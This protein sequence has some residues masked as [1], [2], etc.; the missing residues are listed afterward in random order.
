MFTNWVATAI[1]ACIAGLGPAD[2]SDSSAKMEQREKE[3]TTVVTAKGTEGRVK[4]AAG[5]LLAVRLPVQGGTGYSY[6]LAKQNE[7]IL[8]SQGEP[9]VE[10]EGQSRPGGPEF[11]VFRF[12]AQT[13]GS[14]RP[15]VS[16][17]AVVG[18]K[19]AGKNVSLEGGS[20]RRRARARRS[21]EGSAPAIG[22]APGRWTG[23]KP[24]AASSPKPTP[25]A[26]GTP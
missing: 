15:A 2:L 25:D 8:Q 19:A 9:K 11:H 23:R 3:P 6:R 16:L 12:R 26:P 5:S 22:G 10:H 17:R 14:R 13:K 20:E 4:I 24:S 7:K 21:S 1:A 18:K